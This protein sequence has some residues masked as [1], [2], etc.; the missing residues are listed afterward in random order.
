ADGITNRV[1]R[2][3]AYGNAIN[4]EAAKVFIESYMEAVS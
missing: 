1:G 2:L 3:R 4:A